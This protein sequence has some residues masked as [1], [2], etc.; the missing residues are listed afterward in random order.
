MSSIEVRNARTHN[1]QGIDVSLPHGQV[2]VITGVSGSGKSSLAFETLY[3][4]GLRRFLQTV[5]TGHSRGLAAPP[6]PAVDEIRGLPPT[7][8][9]DQDRRGIHMR[10]TL[11]SLTELADLWQ[12]LFARA[13]VVTCPECGTT[14]ATQSADAIVRRIAQL[15]HATKV[16]LL[17]PLYPSRNRSVRQL[18]QTA[19]K[20][21]FLR[22]RVSGEVRD[23]AECLDDPQLQPPVEVVI[24]RLKIKPG[25]DNRLRGS[26]RTAL[27]LSEGVVL[28]SYETPGGFRDLLLSTR[29]A[30][31]RC[32]HNVEAVEPRHFDLDSPY[33]ACAACTGLGWIIPER[34]RRSGGPAPFDDDAAEW[35]EWVRRHVEP[36]ARL[37][38]ACR[39]RRF[40]PLADHVRVLGLTLPELM[41]LDVQ[42]CYERLAAS[43]GATAPEGIGSVP[44]EG[45]DEQRKAVLHR[46][47]PEVLQRLQLLRDLGVGYLKLGRP[48]V[49][50]SGGELQRARL[51]RCLGTGLF[52][53]AYVLDE[54]TFGL[55]PTDTRRLLDVLRRLRDA[56][57]TVIAVE[58][59]LDV[60]LAADHV[61]E[62]GPAAGPLGGRVVFA[63]PPSRLRDRPDSPTAQALRDEL[64]RPP[65]RTFTAGE[66]GWLK[67]L[68]ACRHNLQHITVAMPVGGLV[69]VAGVSGSGKSSLVLDTLVPLLEGF[70]SRRTADGSG[71]DAAGGPSAGN[72]TPDEAASRWP[73]APSTRIA[74]E[75]VPPD[76]F[77]VVVHCVD[78]A[79]VGRS[80]RSTPA[81]FCGVWNA[82]CALFASTREARLRGFTPARFRFSDP[83]GRCNHCGGLGVERPQ[84]AWGDRFVGRCPLCRGRRFNRQTLAVRYRGL[85]VGDVL[86]MSFEEAAAFF[87]DVPRIGRAA[88]T[89]CEL[90]LGYLNLGQPAPTLSAGEA[91]RLKLARFLLRAGR[92]AGEPAL[93]VLDEPTAGLHALDVA[94][95]LQT[96]H[97]LL[98]AGHTLCVIEHHRDVLRHSDW[99]IELGPGAGPEGGRLV[100]C[101]PPQS[102]RQQPQ[103][104]LAAHL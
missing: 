36:R 58:H 38:P 44:A 90:G 37:C 23:L 62:L 65:A 46:V 31:P 91:Q 89:L 76:R 64:P 96:F 26:V 1:L 49:T 29:W 24:D 2:I 63:G 50:L 20:R 77:P 4:E 28:V 47:L 35:L 12:I 40:A 52:H 9:V 33:G 78:Q 5:S 30:C 81:T 39:G 79:P 55:H 21:G 11:A 84:V 98:E 102:L 6:P 61:V 80:P 93:L 48:A 41:R 94:R 99:I 32:G 82:V 7:L 56:G 42:T 71:A 103:S 45:D 83:A 15:P 75:G 104:S 25:L 88:R 54:P 95:L 51:A 67:I 43:R 57:N 73:C 97:R 87:T 101:G 72:E 86:E 74:F 22:A 66:A 8:A 69:A 14:L 16:V 13:G 92:K 17:A 100:A 85:S 3:A 53:V 59:D 68:D 18:L 34:P 10:M 19:L 60:V 70:L 27:R